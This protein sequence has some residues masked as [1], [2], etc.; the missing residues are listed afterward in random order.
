MALVEWLWWN[1]RP[2][3]FLFDLYIWRIYESRS[4]APALLSGAFANL[5]LYFSAT[6]VGTSIIGLVLRGKFEGRV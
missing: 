4:L 5:W 3:Y 2:G 6:F 1:S